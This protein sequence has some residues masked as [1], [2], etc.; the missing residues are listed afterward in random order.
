[1]KIEKNKQ[2]VSNFINHIWNKLKM[3]EVDNYIDNNYRDHS[4]L[5]SVPPTILEFYDK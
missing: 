2:L 1:M 4:F 5:S 3:E